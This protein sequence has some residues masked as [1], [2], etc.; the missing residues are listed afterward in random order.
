MVS[1]KVSLAIPIAILVASIGC[2]IIVISIM[3]WTPFYVLYDDGSDVVHYAFLLSLRH[4]IFSVIS[5]I[6]G[7]ILMLLALCVRKWT[8]HAR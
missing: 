7:T 5:G 6:I 1:H 4:N 3:F 2:C 8:S